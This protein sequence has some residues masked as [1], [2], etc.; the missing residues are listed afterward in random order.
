LFSFKLGHLGARLFFPDRHTW[1]LW[2]QDDTENT[3]KSSGSS[4]PSTT[5]P[6]SNRR[7]NKS[8]N[9]RNKTDN[10]P[11]TTTTTTDEYDALPGGVDDDDDVLLVDKVVPS[12]QT[13]QVS[14]FHPT[15]GFLSRAHL[16]CGVAPDVNA[17]Q[18]GLDLVEMIQK[19]N[20]T[21]QRSA[22]IPESH[23]Q[24]T[25]MRFFGN[26]TCVVYLKEPIPIETIFTGYF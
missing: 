17:V 4:Q 13:E 20:E 23:D 25:V 10:F 16:T 26:G 3:P 19:E 22:S 6:R 21:I 7:N 5:K 12:N 18:T 1:A 14:F 24:Q 2:S 8:K 11:L 15:F 9:S